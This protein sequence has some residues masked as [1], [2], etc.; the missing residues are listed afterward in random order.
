MV[1]DSGQYDKMGFRGPKKNCDI[2]GLFFYKDQL[3]L[4][5]GNWVC[6]KCDD[7]EEK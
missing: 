3:V 6:P 2:C 5:K 7:E 1:S 4:N